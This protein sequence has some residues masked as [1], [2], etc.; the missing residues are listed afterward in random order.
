MVRMGRSNFKDD[1][2][3]TPII[4][5]YDRVGVLKFAQIL[6]ILVEVYSNKK[7]FFQMTGLNVPFFITSEPFLVAEVIKNGTFSPVISKKKIFCS[8]KLCQNQWELCKF[9]NAHTVV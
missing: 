7:F 5:L 2:M 4:L 3:S 9:Q 6:L 1:I 8:V